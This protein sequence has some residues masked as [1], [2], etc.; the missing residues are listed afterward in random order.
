M[1]FICPVV[2]WVNTG[3]IF[4]TMLSNTDRLRG[5]NPRRDNRITEKS[6]YNRAVQV[7]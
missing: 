5:S 3:S 6:P 4:L 1:I 7:K 2:E